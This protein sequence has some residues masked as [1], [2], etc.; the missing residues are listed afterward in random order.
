MRALV[1]VDFS[2]DIEGLDRAFTPGTG[3]PEIGDLIRMQK[4][5]QSRQLHRAG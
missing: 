5:E 3:N 4:I 2:F 1:V